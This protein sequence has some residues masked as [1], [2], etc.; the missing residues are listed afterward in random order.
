MD[1]HSSL[2]AGAWTV[3]AGFAFMAIGGYHLFQARAQ[4]DRALSFYEN[5]RGWLWSLGRSIL[6]SPG[7]VLSFRV[8]GVAAILLGGAILCL[9]VWSLAH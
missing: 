5:R 3:V 8:A 9:G 2:A 6:L 7:Y 1:M 4:R